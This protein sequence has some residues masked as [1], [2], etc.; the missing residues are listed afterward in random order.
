MLVFV[1]YNN[2][3]NNNSIHLFSAGLYVN[4]VEYLEFKYSIKS[5]QCKLTMRL[6][7]L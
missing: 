4:L 3:N 5:S 1:T 6:V 2:Y 7:K